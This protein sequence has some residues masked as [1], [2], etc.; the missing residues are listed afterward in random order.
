MADWKIYTK[1]GDTGYTSLVGG[2]R[3][4][5]HAIRLDAYGTVD[6]LNAQLGLLI[7]ITEVNIEINQHVQHLLFDLG[8]YLATAQEKDNLVSSSITQEHITLLEN[9]IDDMEQVL[10]PLDGFILPGGSQGIATAHICR[11]VC[12]RAERLV[13]ALVATD[14]PV[15]KH[16]LAFMNRL[17]DYFFV[18]ARLI[19][20]REDI[21]E[22]KWKN[23]GR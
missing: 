17:S 7:A 11:T 10:A 19:A 6:E 5:K 15:D 4:E 9:A 18:L 14:V 20:H 22:I 16:V 8:S 2:Q 21:E 12:R 3:V 23:I 1:G 13:N